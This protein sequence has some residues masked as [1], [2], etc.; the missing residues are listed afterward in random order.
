MT[1]NKITRAALTAL[2][3]VA[4]G[5]AQAFEFSRADY[6]REIRDGVDR[7]MF[8]DVRYNDTRTSQSQSGRDIIGPDGKRLRLE[9]YVERPASDQYQQIILN[10]HDGLTQSAVI[11]KTFN[12]N[13]PAD[14]SLLALWETQR[15]S[16]SLPLFYLTNHVISMTNGTDTF[17]D[18]RAGGAIYLDDG[19]GNLTPADDDLIINGQELF[20][21][22]YTAETTSVNGNER[23]SVVRDP[24][25]GV[26]TL[27]LTVPQ[28]VNP[29]IQTRTWTTYQMGEAFD[30]SVENLNVGEPDYQLAMR[31]FWQSGDG[32]PL[33]RPEDF[34][35]AEDVY[36]GFSV[37]STEMK[38]GS[39]SVVG[40][41]Q[42]F[43]GVLDSKRDAL[44]LP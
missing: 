4:A 2:V 13:L 19:A 27:S 29:G 14:L 7:Q 23:I 41:P 18:R 35:A 25:G 26:V 32:K 20:R 5:S 11:T 40:S 8:R 33:S 1:F 10:R 31:G 39:I 36:S 44:M 22:L 21:H 17:E 15:V 24:V 9:Q 34:S 12:R 38:R 28:D 42:A 6:A 43:F 30:Y 3:G 37:S 16:L